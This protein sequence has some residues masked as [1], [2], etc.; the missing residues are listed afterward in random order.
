MLKSNLLHM[1]LNAINLVVEMEERD[2]FKEFQ[3]HH[4]AAKEASTALLARKNIVKD[5]VLNLI[6]NFETSE[7]WFENPGLLKAH[8]Q[9]QYF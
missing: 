1:A 6:S 3:S 4:P 8:V 5:K 2:L 7:D 9:C